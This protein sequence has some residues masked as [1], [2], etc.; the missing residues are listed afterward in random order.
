MRP[1]CRVLAAATR[2]LLRGSRFDPLPA[3]AAAPV[4]RHLDEANGPPHPVLKPLRSPLVGGGCGSEQNGRVFPGEY[5]PLGLRGCFLSDSAYQPRWTCPPRDV[6][7]HAFST[8]ANAMAAVKSSEDKVQ[9]DVSKKDVDDQIADTQILK[10]LG[11]YLLLND[12]PDFRFRL[13]LSLGLLVGAKVINVQVPFLFKLAVDW[14]AALAGAETSLASFTDANVT[15]LALFASPAAVLIGYG[16]ARSGVSACTELRN[17]VF[18]KVTLT[19]IRSVSRMVFL[20]LH[21]LDLRY[22]LC[23]QT[24]ALNR[25][26]D[27][28][29]RAINYILTVMVFNV[30]PTI[31]EIGMVSSILAYKFGSSFAWITS[32]SV[33]AYV[34]FTLAVTQWRTK[35]RT[36]MNKAEN[37]SSTVAVDSLLNYETVKY[38]NND[39]FEVEKYDKYLKKYEDAALKTQSSLAYLNFGQNI[40]FS[41]ALSTAMVLS[42]YGVMSGALTVGDL[43]MVNGLL[44]QLSLPLNFLGSVY[45]ESRQSLIDMK[46][47]FQLLEEKPG[48]K[49]E[50]HAQPLQFKGGRIEFEN[51]HFG[52]VPERKIL[53]GASFTV[54]AG[55]S[56]AIVGTSGSGKS[57]ILRLLF[58]F[59]DSSSGSIR[60]DG[61][62]IKEV[63]LESLRKCLGVVPQ[64]TVLFN[65][66]IKHNVQYGRLSAKDEEV[67]D[68]ARRAAVHDTIM[69]FPEKYNT[70][71]G[72]R[73]LKLSGGE[74]QRVS[75]ARVFLK[76]PSILLC[77]EATSALDSTTE[78]SILNSLKTFSVK[79]TSIFIAHR[80][81]TAMQCDE[82]IVLENGKVVEQGP[83]DFLLSKGGR[84]SELWSQQNNSDATDA[85]S[86][87]L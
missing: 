29:S 14:L 87:K 13:V 28:G 36:A 34:A 11:K 79:C 6:R 68:A 77:D 75:I 4:F 18:S 46:S 62:D 42:S 76:E 70:V 65:D 30:V 43:V 5:A 84:Y 56:A 32:V 38:F 37:A 10:N 74:K 69:N 20:H 19:A 3:T 24:G 21:E 55:R 9:K 27:R 78:A 17:A 25:I 52:Y 8:S 26:I 51:V 1:S 40:I 41:A 45:R 66:T 15:L 47:M 83:H 22:H 64:D 80:L 50:P 53:D 44:F 71:V 7:W 60:I 82:I 2:H 61:Q 31:L 39:Q 81:T 72:E 35:F 57:T 48:I 33:A 49:D 23:R 85:A 63:T 67:Y 54:P 59:F 73:G 12:S 16:I 58:R 86:V